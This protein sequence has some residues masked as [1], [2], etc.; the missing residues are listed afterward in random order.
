M[1]NRT[2]RVS[3]IIISVSGIKSKYVLCIPCWKQRL[4]WSLAVFNVSQCIEDKLCE[5]ESWLHQK[6]DS[7]SVKKWWLLQKSLELREIFW[8]IFNFLKKFYILLFWQAQNVILPYDIFNIFY[9]NCK[10]HIF[11][12]TDKWDRLIIL[13]SALSQIQPD[14][15]WISAGFIVT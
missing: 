14:S 13:F 8:N 7:I 12:V 2:F 1:L 5:M 3:L 11:L 9:F 4:T 6:D 10:T 15:V